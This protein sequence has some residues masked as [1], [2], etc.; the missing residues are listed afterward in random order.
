[1]TF[2]NLQYGGC[3]AELEEFR[4]RCGVTIHSWPDADQLLYLDDFAAQVAALDLTIS[5]DNTTTHMAG[6]LGRPASWCLLPH[7]ANWRWMLGREDSPWYPA[8]RLFRQ[9]LPSDW[10]AVFEAVSG[11]LASLAGAGTPERCRREP[12]RCP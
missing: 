12:G 7:L 1:V 5:I 10:D 6:A 8:T 4:R 9:Q 3:S 2:V 11:E